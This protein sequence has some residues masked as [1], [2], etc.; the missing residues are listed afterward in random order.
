MRK[1]LTAFLDDV[2]KEHGK[3]LPDTLD[4][5]HEYIPFLATKDTH[6]DNIKQPAIRTTFIGIR[7]IYDMID[8]RLKR[9]PDTTPGSVG[10]VKPKVTPE[11]VTTRQTKEAAQ[12]EEKPPIV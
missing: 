1:H 12:I 7:Q 2:K 5:L 4:L 9:T 8:K 6:F 11:K 3:E 10:K